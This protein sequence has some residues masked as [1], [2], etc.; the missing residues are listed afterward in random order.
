MEGAFFISI[1]LTF[2]INFPQDAITL[3][4]KSWKYYGHQ[5][6]NIHYRFITCAL[7]HGE[8]TK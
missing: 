4:S 5:E 3:K 8:C 6:S 1:R 2:I 7:L